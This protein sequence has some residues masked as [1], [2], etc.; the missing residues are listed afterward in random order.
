MD[1]L[2]PL[3]YRSVIVG[4]VLSQ[5]LR[6]A[7]DI[8]RRCR[9]FSSPQNRPQSA[10]NPCSPTLPQLRTKRNAP[11]LLSPPC[12]SKCQCRRAI[13]AQRQ[14]LPPAH[15]PLFRQPFAHPLSDI[16]P[17]RSLG[18]FF[19]V[20]MAL[21]ASQR[22]RVASCFWTAGD[23]DSADSGRRAGH[24]QCGHGGQFTTD[25][26]GRFRGQATR[27]NVVGIVMDDASNS[28]ILAN[29]GGAMSLRIAVPSGPFLVER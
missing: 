10:I 18:V 1:F 16:F 29:G 24:T 25:R 13:P 12:H 8:R 20:K 19:T 21:A 4:N 23:S 26:N 17:K 22:D 15:R 28:L 3:S 9:I 7:V 27:L 2:L 14:L 6:D 11:A 5:Q